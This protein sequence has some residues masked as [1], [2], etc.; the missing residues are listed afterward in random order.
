MFLR[1]AGLLDE[2]SPADEVEALSSLR[3]RIIVSRLAV[4]LGVL[5]LVGVSIA[6]RLFVHIDAETDFATTSN[7]TH[8]AQVN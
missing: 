2:S 7:A 4:V 6:I 1:G 3:P 5:L 8:P